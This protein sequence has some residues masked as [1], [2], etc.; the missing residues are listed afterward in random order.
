MRR[1]KHLSR[2]PI[3][4][5]NNFIFICISIYSIYAIHYNFIDYRLPFKTAVN[6]Y[7]SNPKTIFLIKSRFYQIIRNIK[8]NKT[9]PMKGIRKIRVV[10]FFP[11]ISIPIFPVNIYI[12]ITT[13]FI[14]FCN[15][16]N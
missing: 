10:K 15:F 16:I 4:R 1:K 12:P 3:P 6:L 7:S 14:L 8:G 2:C 11:I 9:R 13:L 5:T